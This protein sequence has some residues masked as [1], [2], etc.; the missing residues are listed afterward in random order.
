MN[1]KDELSKPINLA[2]VLLSK[3]TNQSVHDDN[4]DDNDRGALTNSTSNYQSRYHRPLHEMDG[5][6]SMDILHESYVAKANSNNLHE[7]PPSKYQDETQT[8]TQYKGDYY[9]RRG[10]ETPLVSVRRAPVSSSSSSSMDLS[11]WRERK[12]KPHHRQSSNHYRASVIE[13]GVVPEQYSRNRSDSLRYVKEEEE[14][15]EGGPQEISM[16]YPNMTP[17]NPLKS[18]DM[19]ETQY[20]SAVKYNDLTADDNAKN[21]A[22]NRL[23]VSASMGRRRTGIGIGTGTGVNAVQSTPAMNQSHASKNISNLSMDSSFP[24]QKHMLGLVGT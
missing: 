2:K 12:L 10:L 23:N 7:I 16:I 5:L 19:N 14:N 4:N 9:K 17:A 15:V 3:A 20:Y 8:H 24:N 13:D 21:N 6:S 1:H 18:G 11:L 22:R